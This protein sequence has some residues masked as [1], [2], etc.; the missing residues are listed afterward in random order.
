MKLRSGYLKA[1]A[2]V[3][4]L[5]ICA[6]VWADEDA[7][8]KARRLGEAGKAW[9]KAVEKADEAAM[10]RIL[11]EDYLHVAADGKV[12]GKKAIINALTT[13]GLSLESKLQDNVRV[14]VYD[15]NAIV[16]GRQIIA[17]TRNGAHASLE[18]RDVANWIFGDNG[19]KL[20]FYQATAV[21][22]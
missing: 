5:S 10:D 12:Y 13:G 7:E 2:L 8:L 19:W 3:R 14:R 9:A 15:K 16:T 4:V 21:R 17:I 1:A 18:V 6:G 20:Q 11:T 22:Q